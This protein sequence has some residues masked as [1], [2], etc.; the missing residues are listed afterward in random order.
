MNG[1][2]IFSKNQPPIP[3]RTSHSLFSEQTVLHE[4]KHY[5]PTQAPLKDF[6][7]HNPLHGFQHRPF[8]QAIQ[9]A[10]ELAGYRVLFSLKEFRALYANGRISEP[11]LEAVILERKGVHQQAI[12]TINLLRKTYPA[13]PTPRIGRL[14]EGWKAYYQ[15]DLDALV[16]PILFRLLCSFLDQGIA[17]S[18]FPYRHLDFL[19]A[20]RAMEQSSLV[21]LF[22]S[23]RVRRLVRSTTCTIPDLM[24]ILVGQES[25]YKQ[26]LFDQQFAHPGWSGM[27]SVIEDQPQSVLDHRRISLQ[28]VIMLELLL[29]ID[30]LD[31]Q[32]GQHWKPL[33][34][35]YPDQPLDL[36][37][38]SVSTEQWEVLC[39][40]QQAYEWS[41]Y[42]QV[43][44]GIQLGP[45]EPVVPPRSFQGIFCL[46]DRE[47]SL[48]RY[49]ET[50]DTNCQTFGT[51]GFFNVEFFFQPQGATAY[52]KL[53]PPPFSP[54][55]LIKERNGARNWRKSIHFSKSSQTLLRGV[56]ISQT[57]GFW[58]ALRLLLT[59][60]R[61]TMRPEMASSYQHMQQASHL[62]VEQTSLQKE[63]GL[64][65]GFNIDEMAERV[66]GLL[67][68]IGLVKE[69]APIVYVI[70]HG[71]SSV[72][73]PYYAAYDCG[74][75]S[76]R[77][78]SV[79]ARVVCLMANDRRVRD[80]LRD[81]GITI[82]DETQFSSGL[83][84]TTRDDI[85]FYDEALLSP[86]NQ[87]LHQQHITLFRQALDQNAKER[88]RRFES[89]DSRLSAAAIHANIR[90][91][92]VSLFEPRPEL[93]HATNAV[94]LIGQRSLSRHLFLD[95][96]S[97]LNSYD[98]RVD[99]KGQALARI[100]QAAVPVCGGI[101][102]EYFFSRVDTQKLG[103]GS[104]LPH[105]VMGL[106]GVANGFDG[107]LRPGLPTQMTEVHDPVRLLMVIEQLPDVVLKA[108]QQSPLTY[109]W[110][111]NDWI[112]LVVV[113]PRTRAL[114]RFTS[115]RF[116]AYKPRQKQVET[117]SDLPSLIAS[118]QTNFPVYRLAENS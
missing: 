32:F 22:R 104:K 69:F 81:K 101:N 42:D 110:F 116:E 45:V 19:S 85:C 53:C 106:I 60:F 8:E 31:T 96:R 1:H 84:D 95:R 97:F 62:T 35:H 43:L 4:L 86:V 58:S 34:H 54:R 21:S 71:A 2:A 100:V 15:L 49:L 39:L 91:R 80:R 51:P 37:A 41:Y 61:P 66:E 92:S 55:Y 105:N 74:A 65:V 38:S 40:W 98:Y 107:D 102:L 17:V 7:H 52:T 108:I 46:D 20:I 75:C 94:C 30:A 88:S 28:A 112:H 36:F 93:N 103:A 26:Y 23:K 6:V 118:D 3:G 14:R 25:L 72:N 68:S 11:L 18:A 79:N 27:V 87:R 78:G 44:A 59:V 56:V 48:R 33:S 83:H 99:P 57:L 114:S 77:P 89:I 12:W 63:N 67:T 113:H 73:N 24:A 9:Q 13:L 50:L 70:G 111:L 5:L 29:E 90:R 47:C 82:P 117:I 109:E 76:G 64:Q 16:H 115:G 10:A